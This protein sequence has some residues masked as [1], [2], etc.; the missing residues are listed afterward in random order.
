MHNGYPRGGLIEPAAYRCPYL[1]K[2]SLL[3]CA[4]FRNEVFSVRSRSNGGRSLPPVSLRSHS[5]LLLIFSILLFGRR[6]VHKHLTKRLDELEI[7][8]DNLLDLLADGGAIAANVR[9]RL[10]AIGEER[11]RVKNE[12]AEQGPLLKAGAG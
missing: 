3:L 1:M 12:L 8:E 6:L 10:L 4:I 9:T 2:P 7:K 11:E 5:I